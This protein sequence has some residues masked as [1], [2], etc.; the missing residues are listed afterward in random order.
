MDFIWIQHMNSLFRINLGHLISQ[1]ACAKTLMGLHE[2]IKVDDDLHSSQPISSADLTARSVINLLAVN[3]AHLRAWSTVLAFTINLTNLTPRW[4]VDAV[5]INASNLSARSIVNI[6]PQINHT[7][8]IFK[9]LNPCYLNSFFI[10]KYTTEANF[11]W[12]S[13]I[14]NAA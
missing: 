9:Y 3:S 7:L 13:R 4:V 1:L 5:S 10:I 8:W 11:Y 12:I 2:E 6:K 14:C